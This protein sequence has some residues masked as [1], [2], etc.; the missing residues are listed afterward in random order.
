MNQCALSPYFLF[1]SS[2]ALV[3]IEITDENDNPPVFIGEP[4]AATINEVSISHG[5][6]IQQ[7]PNHNFYTLVVISVTT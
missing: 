3:D 4:Y 6:F 5:V 7:A 1:F 2:L